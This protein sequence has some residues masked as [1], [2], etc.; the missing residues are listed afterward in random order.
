[1]PSDGATEILGVIFAAEEADGLRQQLVDALRLTGNAPSPAELS[2]SLLPYL[3]PIMRFKGGDNAGAPTGISRDHYQQLLS[4]AA[5]QGFADDSV[6]FARY[7]HCLAVSFAFL[8]SDGALGTADESVKSL[9]MYALAL[10]RE[11]MHLGELA[12]DAFKG[13]EA[14]MKGV[15][16][17]FTNQE[18]CGHALAG[19]QAIMVKKL[20]P[21]IAATMMP[22]RL[23]GDNLAQVVDGMGTDAIVAEQARNAALARE[24]RGLDGSD[25]PVRA[26]MEFGRDVLAGEQNVAPDSQP[27]F[28]RPDFLATEL[29]SRMGELGPLPGRLGSSDP[30][31]RLTAA[32]AVRAS[33]VPLE[34]FLEQG[35]AN[36]KG[37]LEQTLTRLDRDRAAIQSEQPAPESSQIARVRFDKDKQFRLGEITK[38]IESARREA[39]GQSTVVALALLRSSATVLE[40]GPSQ[41]Q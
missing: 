40:A 17:M 13:H 30:V 35:A 4:H 19:S 23:I 36:V 10:H 22:A 25:P 27:D 1:L 20:D 41:A 5:Q 31:A 16:A 2:F 37:D 26:A 11:S 3:Q 34:A 15:D 28:S 39:E 24:L 18:Q 7:L 21:K 6:S 33:L 38:A 8:S 32:A 9:R 29:M 12:P 14:Q